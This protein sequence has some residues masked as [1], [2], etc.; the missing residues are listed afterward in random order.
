MQ[1]TR[2]K[3]C[4]RSANNWWLRSPNASNS[5]NFCYV[6][7]NGNVNNNNA[8]NSNG[9]VFGFYGLWLFRAFV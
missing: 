5:N 7:S 9:A 4:P 6:N 8:N 1:V 3:Y 2:R